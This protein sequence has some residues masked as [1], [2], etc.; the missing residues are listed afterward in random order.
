MR[1]KVK[2][3]TAKIR[4][5]NGFTLIEILVAMFLMV[6]GSMVLLSGS[7]S[8]DE[9]M[10]KTLSNIERSI[11]F[12]ADEAALRN[13]VVRLHFKLNLDPQ[14]F[15][16]EYGPNAQYIPPPIPQENTS[17]LSGSEL[18][19]YKKTQEQNTKKFNRIRELREESFQVFFPLKVVGV[20]LEQGESLIYDGE[21]SIY[22][23][24]S[25]EKDPAIIIL[26]DDIQ[27]KTLTI[28][29]YTMEFQQTTYPLVN[30]PE[31]EQVLKQAQDIFEKWKT[32]EQQE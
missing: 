6:M 29:P 31:W 2:T 7:A 23:Y 14:E 24:P 11:R 26:A 5:Q 28:E 32:D 3:P 17:E 8:S 13:V 10:E 27:I 4:N 30:G 18:E 20:G 9:Q 16:V 21:A 15:A 12:G 1:T 25:A 22:I 19:E